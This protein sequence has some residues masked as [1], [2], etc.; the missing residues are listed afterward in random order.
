[1]KNIARNFPIR[2]TA[3]KNLSLRNVVHKV[4]ARDHRTCQMCGADESCQCPYAHNP[5]SLYVALVTASTLDGAPQEDDLRTVCS[6]CAD[7][8]KALAK[9]SRNSS[10]VSPIAK[11]SLIEILTNIRRATIEDQKAVL[12]WMLKKFK[13]KA[14]PEG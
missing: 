11:A 2:V 3:L 4:V 7:G 5:I 12:E 6:T 8:L 9:K 1:M 14:V 10:I 13:L